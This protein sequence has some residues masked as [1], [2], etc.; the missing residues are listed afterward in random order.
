MSRTKTRT[1]KPA[2]TPAL[3]VRRVQPTHPDFLTEAQTA[4]YHA[5]LLADL[6]QTRIQDWTPAPGGGAH[7]THPNGTRI[8]HLP[9]TDIPFT[10]LTPCPNGAT[11]GT[12]V[13]TRTQ[14]DNAVQ[15]ANQCTR[16]HGQPRTLTLAQAATT[17]ADTQQ[18]NGN[19][20]ATGLTHRAT[21]TEQPKEHPQ[22]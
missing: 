9:G 11:H 17:A 10:A 20:I 6:P 13:A 7:H 18:L 19:D 14:Y 4:A 12:P 1:P 2:P 21:D 16:L 22:P 8:Q 5:A 3:P 15:A